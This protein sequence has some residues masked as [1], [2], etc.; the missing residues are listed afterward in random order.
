MRKYTLVQ[1]IVSRLTDNPAFR[2]FYTL[3]LMAE[4]EEERK[5]IDQEFMREA[6]NLNEAEY[7]AFRVEFT[8]CVKR[9]PTLTSQLYQKVAVMA[10][11]VPG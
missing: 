4:T 3:Y 2:T 10:Q 8:N 6:K 5:R 7:R 1:D 9:L 11:S